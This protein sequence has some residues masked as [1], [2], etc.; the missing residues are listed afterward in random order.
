MEVLDH[1]GPLTQAT[2][3]EGDALRVRPQPRVKV[4]EGALQVVLLQPAN[5][6][7]KVGG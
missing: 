3:E 7:I 5:V 1:D 4:S 2:P 6:A